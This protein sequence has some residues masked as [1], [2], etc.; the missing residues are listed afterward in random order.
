M[1][2][3]SYLMFP[4]KQLIAFLFSPALTHSPI[5]PILRIISFTY[6]INLAYYVPRIIHSF[7]R[8]PHIPL[9]S[10]RNIFHHLQNL[11]NIHPGGAPPIQSIDY[12]QPDLPKSLHRKITPDLKKYSMY[13]LTA[14]LSSG[15]MELS[16]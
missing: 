11:F 8:I 15:I 5:S 2:P 14:Y 16:R 1:K 6:K 3:Q 12:I 10:C 4:F 13:L 9:I 7:L